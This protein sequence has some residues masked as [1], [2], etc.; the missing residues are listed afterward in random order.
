MSRRMLLTVAVLLGG[1]RAGLGADWIFDN[2]PYTRDP[3]THQRVDQFRKPAK[4]ERIPYDQY[5]SKDGPGTQLPYWY[6]EDQ[7]FLPGGEFFGPFGFGG[8]G[9]GFGGGF[10]MPSLPYGG[11][12]MPYAW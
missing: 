6:Y 1:A 5:F 3:K 10:G 11:G 4:A 2:G 12:A 7:L 8:Y 9:G